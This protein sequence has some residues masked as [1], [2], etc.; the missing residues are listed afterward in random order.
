MWE[1]VEE[2]QTALEEM[3]YLGGEWPEGETRVWEPLSSV[4]QRSSNV[5]ERY[6]NYNRIAVTCHQLVIRALTGKTLD[7]AEFIEFTL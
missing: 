7:L 2:V 1:T 4:R 3:D 6:T 5:L